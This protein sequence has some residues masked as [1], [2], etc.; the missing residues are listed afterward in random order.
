MDLFSTCHRCRKSVG[1]FQ[2]FSALEPGRCCL[3]LLLFWLSG[4]LVQGTSSADTAASRLRADTDLDGERKPGG[5]WPCKA[6]PWRLP[7]ASPRSLVPE[8]GPDCKGEQCVLNHGAAQCTCPEEGTLHTFPEEPFK[9][10][11]PLGPQSKIPNFL[12]THCSN[13]MLL[14]FLI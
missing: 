6:R 7:L 14:V 2:L 10:T 11:I 3:W 12:S 9:L 13:K 4:G 1:L 5:D 8:E